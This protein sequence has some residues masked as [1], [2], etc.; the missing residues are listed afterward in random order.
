MSLSLSNISAASVASGT[1]VVIRYAFFLIGALVLGLIGIT[2]ITVSNYRPKKIDEAPAFRIAAP[3][4]ARL[5]AKATV[6]VGGSIGRVEMR[7]YGRIYD[8]DLDMTVI[9]RFPPAGTLVGHDVGQQLRAVWPLRNARAMF[10]SSYYDLETRFGAVRA[11]E[12]R[13]ESDGQWKQCLAFVSRFDTDAFNLS[14]WYCDASG[15]RPNPYK[16][17]C[18]L[19]RIVL[20][21]SPA[22]S[23][24]DA[25][26]RAR[27]AKPA[28][29]AASPVAQTTDTR[30]RAPARKHLR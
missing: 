23:E 4:L 3:E 22:S 16:V 10:L 18:L 2:I 21:S 1:G 7:Q 27:L 28:S 17:A 19:D 13:I 9:L 12:M 26:L 30:L 6:A 11:A 8:R 25:F 20:D 14:G 29:C 15:A 24:A 5:P